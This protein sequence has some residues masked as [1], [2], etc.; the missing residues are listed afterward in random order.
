MFGNMSMKQ[1]DNW[2]MDMMVKLQSGVSDNF[3]FRL[4][5][6]R[7]T[8]QMGLRVFMMFLPALINGDWK[9]MGLYAPFILGF[10]LSAVRNEIFRTTAQ[11]FNPL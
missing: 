9:R 3:V 10:V 6:Y 2:A 5:F 7:V 11:G 8:L 1:L 4:L